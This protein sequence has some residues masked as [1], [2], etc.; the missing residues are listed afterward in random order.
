MTEVEVF[1]PTAEAETANLRSSPLM[2]GARMGNRAG[3]GLCPRSQLGK[4]CHKR[5]LAVQLERSELDI[6]KVD[7]EGAE[8]SLFGP[9]LL[10][11]TG[12]GDRTG[13]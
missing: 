11:W 3:G 7:V 2:P 9:T 10:E 5:R 8:D 6:L 1:N 12:T 4:V 13:T